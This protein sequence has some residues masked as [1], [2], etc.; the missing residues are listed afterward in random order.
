MFTWKLSYHACQF[1]YPAS[2]CLLSF[3]SLPLTLISCKRNVA[4]H[5]Q[6]KKNHNK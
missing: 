2:H 3:N 1:F 5:D 4:N 6:N